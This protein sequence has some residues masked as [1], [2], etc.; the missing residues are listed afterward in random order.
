MSSR[1]HR[2]EMGKGSYEPLHVVYPEVGIICKSYL[3]QTTWNHRFILV[4]GDS[5][6]NITEY[7]DSGNLMELDIEVTGYNSLVSTIKGVGEVTRLG[8]KLYLIL[9]DNS[10]YNLGYSYSLYEIDTITLSVVKLVVINRDLLGLNKTGKT[11][12]YSPRLI[13]LMDTYLIL[14]IRTS[15]SDSPAWAKYE[16][17][18]SLDKVKW[19]KMNR[20]FSYSTNSDDYPSRC[21]LNL[22]YNIDNYLVSLSGGVDTSTTYYEMHDS[23][24]S[25]LINGSYDYL[26]LG[27]GSGYNS[28]IRTRPGS[29]IVDETSGYYRLPIIYGH[30]NSESDNACFIMSG[31][32][33]SYYYIGNGFKFIRM[34]Y[35]KFNDTFNSLAYKDGKMYPIGCNLFQELVDDVPRWNGVNAKV[36]NPVAF[37][38]DDF[39]FIGDLKNNLFLVRRANYESGYYQNNNWKTQYDLYE[40]KYTMNVGSSETPVYS[41]SISLKESGILSDIVDV[42]EDLSAYQYRLVLANYNFNYIDLNNL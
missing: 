21:P 31:D 24:N 34:E 19:T 33:N 17:Y 3:N 41:S 4:R 42:T 6:A 10:S 35:D 38:L 9:D 27:Y 40:L 13:N 26:H 20:Y 39:R 28:S 18:Y 14:E 12:L 23:I 11:Q 2:R 36:G 1:V 8:D 5:L 29:I 22:F 15:E 16:Y 30:E 32:T 25:F 7:D 37:P